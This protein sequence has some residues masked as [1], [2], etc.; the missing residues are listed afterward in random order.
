M[1]LEIATTTGSLLG[2]VLVGSARRRHLR[3]VR[4]VPPLFG[5][6]VDR[7]AVR[8]SVVGG[9][10]RLATR[11]RLDSSYPTESGWLP[12]RG[13]PGAARLRPGVGGRNP[14][15]PVGHRRRRVESG[16][17]GSAMRIPFKVS[18]ATSNS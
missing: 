13:A 12:Y 3:A 5:D 10:D 15:G 18:T 2:A 14:R 9:R 7:R 11:L 4:D 8:R 16:G 1:F 6:G 17:D